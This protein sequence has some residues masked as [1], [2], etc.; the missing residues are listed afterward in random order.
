MKKSIRVLRQ[1]RAYSSK[2]YLYESNP[3]TI[4]SLDSPFIGTTKK[5]PFKDRLSNQQHW[6]EL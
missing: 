3:L 5:I 4:L 2:L 6:F 1:E